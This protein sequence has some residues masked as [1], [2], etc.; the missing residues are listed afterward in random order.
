M[1]YHTAHTKVVWHDVDD[2]VTCRGSLKSI[3]CG[4]KLVSYG[5]LLPL[6]RLSPPQSQ[7]SASLS[8][9][10]ALGLLASARNYCTALFG[11]DASR[12][13]HAATTLL[14]LRSCNHATIHHS[15]HLMHASIMLSLISRLSSSPALHKSHERILSLAWHVLP[16]IMDGGSWATRALWEGAPTMT[17]LDLVS[18][19]H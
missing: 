15:L 19:F 16:F 13:R 9:P 17:A 6:T 1:N 7:S 2:V 11:S 14:V 5:R 4:P 3:R 12:D 18:R 8:I 10:T